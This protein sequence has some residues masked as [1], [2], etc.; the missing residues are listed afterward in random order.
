MRPNFDRYREASRAIFKMLSEITPLV[1]PVSIDEGYLDITDTKE[2][3]TPVEIADYLQQR[4]LRELDIPCSLGIAP[5]KFL[6]KMA[7]D[8]RKP[9]GIT[10]LRKRELASTLWPLQIEEMHGIGA[11]T[12]EKLKKSIYSYDW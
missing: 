6:A 5:N 1:Q 9:L 11:K 4:I 12:A 8:M 10:I 7:S 2:L 3:G